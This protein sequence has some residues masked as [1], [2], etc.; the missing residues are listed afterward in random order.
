MTIERPMFPPVDPT[1]RRFLAVAA[2]ASIAGAG[3]LAY[4]AASPNDVPLAVTIPPAAAIAGHDPVFGMIEAHRKADRDHEA[5][6]DEQERLER[7]GDIAAAYLAGEASC[8]AAFIAFDVLLA[9]PA[10]T[11]PG[12]VAKLAYLQDIAHRDAWMFTDRP[13]AAIL[14][15]EGFVASVSNVWRVQ[16]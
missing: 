5:A 7:I 11:L 16:S 4:V 14:L 10:A 2:V 15:L 8:H 3:S 6:L 1:R 12:I 9:A 13:D